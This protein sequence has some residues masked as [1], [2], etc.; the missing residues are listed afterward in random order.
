MESAAAY[1]SALRSHKLQPN[2][3]VW[4]IPAGRRKRTVAIRVARVTLAHPFRLKFLLKFGLDLRLSVS[5]TVLLEPSSHLPKPHFL[6]SQTNAAA[7]AQ[8]SSNS[9][10]DTPPPQPPCSS[11]KRS[12]WRNVEL[13]RPR[14][15][16]A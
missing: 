4:A 5:T 12:S 2:I 14:R 1:H 15:G 13:R 3:D 8:S 6:Q 11:L 10:E 16:K 7:P 9:M